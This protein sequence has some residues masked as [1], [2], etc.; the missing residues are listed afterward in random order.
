MVHSIK[1]TGPWVGSC[2][3]TFRILGYVP[4]VRLI[5]V[6]CKQD[7]ILSL[8]LSSDNPVI[9]MW[10]AGKTVNTTAAPAKHTVSDS[11]LL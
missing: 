7:S 9:T 8:G 4:E 10:V 6:D 11:F 2:T 1:A 5:E 3:P